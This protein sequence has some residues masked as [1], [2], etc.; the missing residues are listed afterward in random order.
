MNRVVWVI[1][2][3]WVVR[4]IRVIS[5]I[6]VIRDLFFGFLFCRDAHKGYPCPLPASFVRSSVYNRDGQIRALHT[7]E[8]SFTQT[9]RTGFMIGSLTQTSRTGFMR[10]LSH[11]NINTDRDVSRCVIRQRRIRLE[12]R[13]ALQNQNVKH[14]LNQR[15]YIVH[16]D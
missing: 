2:V 12:I 11:T 3:V 5:V 9:S 15:Y 10:R 8:G 16:H 13:F 7:K 1:R 4:V 14:K 6:R